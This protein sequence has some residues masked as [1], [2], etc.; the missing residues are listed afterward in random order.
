MNR[1]KSI[2]K[3]TIHGIFYKFT[4]P[5]PVGLYIINFIFQ[6]I[7]RINSEYSWMIN[8]TSRLIGKIEIGENVKKSFAVSGGCYFQANNGIT[9]GDNTI[10]APNVSIISS[11]HNL[12]NL[13]SWEKTTPINIGKNCWI[14]T[15]VVIL[16]GTTLGNNVIVGANSVVTKSFPSNC[17]IVGNPAK[18]IKVKNE[19]N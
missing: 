7:F 16:P 11:N 18:I 9:I 3:I 1:L 6:R 14:G 2:R 13:N 15:G 12:S 17:T 19:K 10:F 8:F 4:K 5:I